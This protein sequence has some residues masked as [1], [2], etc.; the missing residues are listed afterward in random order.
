MS[1]TFCLQH[2]I[3]IASLPIAIKIMPST[4]QNISSFQSLFFSSSLIDIRPQKISFVEHLFL[5]SLSCLVM[6]LAKSK[7]SRDFSEVLP[8]ICH[9]E[10]QLTINMMVGEIAIDRRYG[11]EGKRPVIMEKMVIMD[12]KNIAALLFLP[13]PIQALLPNTVSCVLYFFLYFYCFW[14]Y[15]DSVVWVVVL[16]DEFC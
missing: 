5:L 7:C 8:N 3:F 6:S 4:F 9:Y 10:H 14:L 11:R 15:L 2:Y 16:G 1:K 12:H 13:K